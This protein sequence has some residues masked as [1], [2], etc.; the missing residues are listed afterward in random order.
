ME[1]NQRLAGYDVC[2]V[3]DFYEQAEAFGFNSSVSIADRGRPIMRGRNGMVRLR[4]GLEL[5]YSEAVDLEDVSIEADCPP[6]I[7]VKVFLSGQVD[8]SIGGLRLPMPH[9]AENSNWQPVALLLAQRETARFIRH[10][11][12]GGRLRKVTVSFTREWL[13]ESTGLAADD[14]AILDEFARCHLS[15]RTWA[16]SQAAISTVEQILNPPELPP[17]VRNL[18]LESRALVLVAEAMQVLLYGV[19]ANRR[20]S[21]RP[22]HRKRLEALDAFLTTCAGGPLNVDDLAR[23]TGT[24]ANT[25]RRLVQAAH[26]Q[27]LTEYVRRRRLERARYGLEAGAMSIAEAAF[28]SGYQSTA[29]FSTAFRRQFGVSPRKVQPIG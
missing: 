10:S 4:P 12:K 18:Y 8:A 3:G 27:S 11:T 13:D 20:S 24:S 26:R 17:A 15:M 29:N 9:A 19:R 23:Y 5:H 1:P 14:R 16:P 6:N 21:L 7:S 28:L 25:L 2:S 22:E